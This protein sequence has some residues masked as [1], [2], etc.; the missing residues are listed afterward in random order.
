MS[1]WYS[2]GAEADGDEM[3]ACVGRLRDYAAEFGCSFH[4]S[5][6]IVSAFERLLQQGG[7][8][9][10]LLAHGARDVQELLFICKQIAP[11]YPEKLK[12]DLPDLIKGSALPS[13]EGRHQKAR[14]LQFEYLTAAELMEAGF[15][16]TLEEPDVVF[17]HREHSLGL[18]AKR[19]ISKKRV[20]DR[21]EKGVDQIAERSEHGGIVALCLD[22]LLHDGG[23][24]FVAGG[25]RAVDEGLR[26][27][28]LDLFWPY[29]KQAQAVLAP[30]RITGIML[31]LTVVGCVQ[32][33]PMHANASVWVGRPDGLVEETQLLKSIVRVLTRVSE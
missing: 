13:Q 22:R 1:E 2:G 26:S 23:A 28:V 11:V 8:D 21:I 16:V 15:R 20:V 4:P 6:R 3:L 7:D 31:S 30:T 10:A 14:S 33:D 12:A 5:S 32:G 17:V 18:A 9:H 27:L 24:S 25:D 19:P 29:R